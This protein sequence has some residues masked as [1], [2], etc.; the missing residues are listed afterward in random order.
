MWAIRSSDELLSATLEGD[1]EK[2]ASMIEQAHQENTSILKY[3][4]ENALAC[5]ISLA[6]YSAKKDY[7]IYRELAGGKG[8]AD[9]VFIPR[10]NVNKPAIVVE[11]K[12]NK[13]VSAAIEQIKEKQYVQSLKGYSGEVVLVGVNYVSGKEENGEFK[14]HECRI[15]R[16]SV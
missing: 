9:M 6:Y 14:K 12:W 2:T 4:D 13:T 7:L 1:E 5:V 11:L 10:N 16:V 15:E 8:Y 3:N